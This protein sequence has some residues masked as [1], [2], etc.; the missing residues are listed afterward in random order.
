MR[1]ASCL[2]GSTTGY[3]AVGVVGGLAVVGL[4]GWAL[5]DAFV[6]VPRRYPRVVRR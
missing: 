4:L 2:R 5:Y 6:M 3:Q 1:C